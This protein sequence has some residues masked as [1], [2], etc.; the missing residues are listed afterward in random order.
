MPDMGVKI[1][2]RKGVSDYSKL[3]IYNRLTS[4][5]SPQKTAISIMR[6]SSRYSI[7]GWQKE[8]QTST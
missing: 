7:G 2:Y 1:I 5:Y 3:W 6:I 4:R 8:N